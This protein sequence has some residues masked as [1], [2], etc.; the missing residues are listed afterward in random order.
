[1]TLEIWLSLA[2]IHITAVVTP[3]ANFLAVTQTA[4]TRSRRAG[5]WVGGG[6]ITGSF[7]H[8]AAGMIGFAAI[9][10]RI[11]VL[12]AAIRLLGGL[13]FAY[14]GFKM[15][16]AAYRQFR[17]KQAD[18]HIS[19]Q[20]NLSDLT[21]SQAYRRGLLTHLSNPAS[22]LYYV[23]LYTGFVPAAASLFEKLLIAVGLLGSTSL[24][25]LL[26]AIMFSQPRIRRFYFR[27]MPYMNTLFGLLWIALA[28]K[29]IFA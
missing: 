19:T 16:M 17:T 21:A 4:L 8:I 26:V 25:Y 20:I 13:Y 29:L 10:S 14:T 5:L 15:L 18:I 23:S 2:V 11:P 6:I 1:M 12:F 28:V 24:W 7:I 27:L 22:M 3:G 9:I